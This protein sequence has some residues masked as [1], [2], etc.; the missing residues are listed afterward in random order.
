MNAA[1]ICVI[2]RENEAAWKLALR[3]Y[4][5]LVNPRKCQVRIDAPNRWRQDR[6]EQLRI[7]DR[8]SWI[9]K[10]ILLSLDAVVAQRLFEQRRRPAVVKHA[11]ANADHSA[12]VLARPKRHRQPRSQTAVT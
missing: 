12:M 11:G 9:G 8:V 1:L 4:A 5:G 2:L 3:G 7:G 10:H 6:T